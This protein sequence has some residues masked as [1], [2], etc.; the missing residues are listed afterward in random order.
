MKVSELVK[1]LKS[2]NPDGIIEITWEGIFRDIEKKSIYQAQDGTVIID[3][4]ENR[5]KG[6]IQRVED[7]YPLRPNNYWQKQNLEYKITT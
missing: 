7:R 3:A 5:Y 6:R 2:F 4:D 1:Q